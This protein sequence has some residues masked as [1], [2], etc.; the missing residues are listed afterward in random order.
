MN[1]YPLHWYQQ[2]GFLGQAPDPSATPVLPA[3]AA[4]TPIATGPAT[5]PGFKPTAQW[6][7]EEAA[8]MAAGGYKNESPSDS[9]RTP[10]IIGGVVAGVALIG[11]LVAVA[12]K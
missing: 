2:P 7:A 8:I 10:W 3:G 12:K 11:I 4:S 5:A 1:F 9:S 6:T